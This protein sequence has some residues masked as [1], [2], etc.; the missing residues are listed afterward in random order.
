MHDRVF[1]LT[2]ASEGETVTLVSVEGGRGMRRRL[3]DM[4]LNEGVKMRV[5]Q[6]QERGPCIIGV[7]GLRFM[8]GHGMAHRIMVKRG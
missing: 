2:R 1:P 3:T 4:G 5:I 6:A 7:G 8:L